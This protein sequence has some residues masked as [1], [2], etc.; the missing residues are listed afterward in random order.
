M[1]N[2][3]KK[4]YKI[5]L[6][7]TIISAV[8]VFCFV[9]SNNKKIQQGEVKTVN[10]YSGKRDYQNH[11]EGAWN[12]EKSAKWVGLHKA[13]IDINFNSISKQ[14]NYYED[15]LLVIDISGSM[16]GAKLD[17]VKSDSIELTEALLSNTNNR[18]GLITF[19]T[20]AAKIFDFTNDKNALLNKLN[21]LSKF[22]DTNYY[23]SFVKVDEMLSNYQEEDNRKL[24]V[25]FLTDGYPNVDT[26]NEVA[27]Y[28]LLKEK[29]PYADI[30]GIQYEMGKDILEP[31]VK[32][33]DEQYIADML[34]LNNV[35][36]DAATTSEKFE[37]V[38]I[39]DYIDED[40]YVESEEDI[41]PSVGSIKLEDEN[42]K[43]K[44]TWTIPSDTLR[45]GIRANL[46]INATLKEQ[47]YEKEYVETNEKEI[48]KVKLEGDEEEVKVEEL[49]P[50]LKNKFEVT[51]DANDLLGCDPSEVPEKKS[52]YPFEPIVFE[53]NLESSKCKFTGW[54]IETKNVNKANINTF[55]MPSTDVLIKGKWNKISL[56]KT[57]D[58]TVYSPENDNT[59]EEYTDK[60]LYNVVKREALKENGQAMEYTRETN[61]GGGTEKVYYYSGDSITNN[62]VIFAGYC[63]KMIRTTDT[64]GVKIIYN[65]TPDNGSCSNTGNSSIVGTS[66]FNSSNNSLAYSGYMYNKVYDFKAGA[67]T[68][69][70]LYGA[71]F[72][73][74]NGTYRLTDTTTTFD[75]THHYSCNNTFGSC[76]SVRYYYYRSKYIL[77]TGGT[78]VS[79]ALEQMLSAANVNSKNSTIKTY[80]DNWYA[81]NIRRYD[82]NLEDVVFCNDRTISSLA[83]FKPNGGPIV[84][85]YLSFYGTLYNNLYCQNNT[86]K[87]TVSTDR[88]NGNLK[89]PVGLLTASEARLMGSG[90]YINKAYWLMTPGRSSENFSFFTTCTNTVQGLYVSGTAGVR[91]VVSLRPYIYYNQGDG[92]ELFPYEV[93]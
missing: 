29:Y 15:V 59:G 61:D 53:K 17:K 49:K 36:F 18:V 43:Q 83:G 3:L 28:Q 48:V 68:K 63:W 22:F 45:T 19:S 89:Y 40:F 55:I 87:F 37:S 60:L 33:S 78:S 12:L 51:Y 38:E 7:F 32:V 65:G 67:P 71:D 5:M 73:Y 90:A 56:D 57:M 27:Q 34:T 25:L 82:S 70:T 26:P 84:G 42:G 54:N 52:Y 79:E 58:G 62:N 92:S 69:G 16:E 1:L 14:N 4:H 75:T 21:D 50:R 91:P 64:G 88:G 44:I 80:I 85:S 30:K 20:S 35:L 86:D 6:V 72:T 31:I 9:L 47:A 77:L 93:G 66:A 24:I 2:M 46:K 81:N 39:I 74:S 11:E 41:I 13:Q 8:I 10:M 23:A 76:S